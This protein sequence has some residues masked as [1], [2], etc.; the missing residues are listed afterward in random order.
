MVQTCQILTV[1]ASC[2]SPYSRYL[3]ELPK[4]HQ[5]LHVLWAEEKIVPRIRAGDSVMVAAHKNSLRALWK[6][7]ENLC[8]K[9]WRQNIKT[10]HTKH[11]AAISRNTNLVVHG[12]VLLRNV[13][14]EDAL[15]IKMMPASAPLVIEF[16]IPPVGDDLIF[17]RKYSLN[18]PT[19]NPKACVWWALTHMLTIRQSHDMFWTLS[20]YPVF[21][22]MALEDC[23]LIGS[24]WKPS[25]S[26]RNLFVLWQVRIDSLSNGG[27]TN[28]APW[29]Q[30]ALSSFNSF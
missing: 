18:A 14:D 25:P 26:D 19:F 24:S 30:I 27:V 4:T 21:L 11:E 17:L 2:V 6:H 7:L 15:D 1:T 20:T 9:E 10:K 22:K 5:R 12:I 3:Q 28:K 13:P 8:C 23:T 16:Q 29:R